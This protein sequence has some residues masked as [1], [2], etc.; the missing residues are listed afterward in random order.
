MINSD[1]TTFVSGQKDGTILL[2]KNKAIVASINP[3]E[4]SVI[5]KW[6][7]VVYKKQLLRTL[8]VSKH[9]VAVE[10]DAESLN[11]RKEFTGRRN[12]QPLTLDANANYLVIGYSVTEDFDDGNVRL[13]IPDE[14]K[15][16]YV[17]V[18][19]RTQH[20]GYR[21]YEKIMV[22]NLIYFT[23]LNPNYPRSICMEKMSAVL[24]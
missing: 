2:W 21:N 12:C 8:A 23:C 3:F 11:F 16:A 9:E 5:D 19:S 13:W 15:V 10:L 20:D 18:H 22:R 14:A 17:D 1:D 4:Q 7:L 6:P 24:L